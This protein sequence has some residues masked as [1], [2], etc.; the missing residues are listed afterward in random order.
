VFL[1]AVSCR[2]ILEGLVTDR[3]LSRMERGAIHGDA[4]VA[5]ACQVNRSGAASHR[6]IEARIF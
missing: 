1:F 6:M 4:A 2:S 3:S 5:A